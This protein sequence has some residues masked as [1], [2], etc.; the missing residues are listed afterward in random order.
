MLSGLKP[1]ERMKLTLSPVKW[2]TS[3]SSCAWDMEPLK[4]ER[5][6]HKREQPW[7]NS[8]QPVRFQP[9][10]LG[11]ECLATQCERP[12]QGSIHAAKI[13]PPT[14]AFVRFDGTGPGDG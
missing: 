13:C 5:A 12:Q 9:I 7:K 10:L 4:K 2:A 8:P 3:R 11:R 14:T 6:A 1:I